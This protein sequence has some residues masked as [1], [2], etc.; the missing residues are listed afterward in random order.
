MFPVQVPLTVIECFDS[1]Y[2]IFKYIHSDQWVPCEV[3]LLRVTDP[4]DFRLTVYEI[5][6]ALFDMDRQY[7]D[8]QTRSSP[9]YSLAPISS[10]SLFKNNEF[11]KILAYT[12]FTVCEIHTGNFFCTSD[13][14][15]GSLRPLHKEYELFI[16]DNAVRCPYYYRLPFALA[17]QRT[18][19]LW[20]LEVC[21]RYELKGSVGFD[22]RWAE[23]NRRKTHYK[24]L[25]ANILMEFDMT[26]SYMV[27]DTL[28]NS[29]IEIK[30]SLP[31]NLRIA[32]I[33][34]SRFE[35]TNDFYDKLWDLRSKE[36]ASRL[37]CQFPNIE[38]NDEDISD[39]Q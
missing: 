13:P 3:K 23:I 31:Q 5:L 21:K 35:G 17:L 33:E 6:D 30:L 32:K 15:D 1:S 16:I 24:L 9:V 20:L 12:V 27:N 39:I 18:C 14:L 4:S 37:S 10:Y 34:A 22:V 28:L 19:Y 26:K 29:E 36:I 2:E 8:N 25:S 11:V 38:C 7:E